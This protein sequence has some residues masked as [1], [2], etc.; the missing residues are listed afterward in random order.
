MVCPG[1]KLYQT[2]PDWILCAPG[3]QR[4]TRRNQFVLDFGRSEVRGYILEKMS[5]LL[6]SCDISYVK[7]DMNRHITEAQSGAAD[8]RLGEAAHRHILG[9]YTVLGELTAKFPKVRVE[10][11]SGG[12]GRFD[13]GML[14]F[15]PQ[16]WAS[17]NTDAFSR[18][19]IQTGFSLLYPPSTMA[20]HISAMPNHQ[21]MRRLP[22]KL[23]AAV[24]MMGSFGLE[25]DVSQME[26]QSVAELKSYVEVYKSLGAILY[27]RGTKYYRLEDP[28][29]MMKHGAHGHG[30]CAWS[31]VT[32]DGSDGFV[33]GTMMQLVE[34]GK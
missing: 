2:H 29:D 7:W 4:T 3:R 30:V 6:S 33:F 10:T 19:R 27:A 13:L 17:D 9:V 21:T 12:G 23:S 14:Y 25:L 15:S 28:F 31:F 32:A 8:A 1:T 22:M 11:C 24:A 34:I 18:C 5:S 16:I 26:M 20:A